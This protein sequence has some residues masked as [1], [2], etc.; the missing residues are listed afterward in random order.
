[1]GLKIVLI[2]QCQEEEYSGELPYSGVEVVYC[3][4]GLKEQD[5]KKS[6]CL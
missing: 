2:A 5:P 3:E 1:M 6:K 4:P